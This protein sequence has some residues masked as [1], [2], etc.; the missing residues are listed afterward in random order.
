[1]NQATGPRAIRR[2]SIGVRQILA[3]CLV[4]LCGSGCTS[5][6]S[7]PV[8]SGAPQSLAWL[9]N[10]AATPVETAP[11]FDLAQI[12]PAP[13]NGISSNDLLEVTIWD[14][15]E[16]GKP[17]TFP[18]R[19]DQQG[20]IAVPQLDPITVHGATP[21]EV[22][23]R[24]VAAYRDNDLL[25]QPR[26][27]VR[28]LASTPLHIYVTGAV[29]RPGL[30][31]LPPHDPSVFAAL[32]GAGGL[33]RNAGLHVFVS[34][35]SANRQDRII[36]ASVVDSP[37]TMP[38]VAGNSGLRLPPETEPNVAPP[39]PPAQDAPPTPV[40]EP[41]E[42]ALQQM[43]N[44]S[45]SLKVPEDPHSQT[46]SDSGQPSKSSKHGIVEDVATRPDFPSGRANSDQPGRWYD[47]SVDRDRETLKQLTLRDG[48]M[49]TVRPAA[50]PVRITGAVTQP[51]SYRAPASNALTL[52]DAI[53]LAGGFSASDKLMFVV[54]TRPANG[55]HGLQRWS[56]RMGHGEPL[57][58][59]M[60]YVQ[61]GDLVHVEPT[62]QARVQSLVDSIWPGTH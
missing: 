13:K 7:K 15:Y 27:L 49:V 9:A 55:E 31:D 14:L 6:F 29:L 58:A 44:H 42:P 38:L 4:C 41:I 33:S 36:Q 45:E 61:P 40:D 59:N 25:K 62:A 8:I 46:V 2:R 60:P 24:L 39:G 3:A 21:A 11:P 10:L 54:L 48:D 57:P 17:H 47:L 23:A 35:R 19:V 16:P 26:V 18:T 12:Q 34:D 53:Q 28:E 51:G 52:L 37:S 43:G 32:V 30:I 1:M 5:I 56:F 20:T 50:P 22:E